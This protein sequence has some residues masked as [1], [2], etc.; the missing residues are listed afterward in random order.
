MAIFGR[1]SFQLLSQLAPD[2]RPLRLLK[3]MIYTTKR[4]WE[5]QS[6][7][8]SVWPSLPEKERKDTTSLLVQWLSW[9]FKTQERKKICGKTGFQLDW[10]KTKKV[11]FLGGF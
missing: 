8:V 6:E 4:S 10:K 9:V 7:S 11:Y 5:K 1:D 3:M 2:T